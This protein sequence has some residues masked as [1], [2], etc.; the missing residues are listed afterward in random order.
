MDA[1]AP[2]LPSRPSA[3]SRPDR[4]RAIAIGLAAAFLLAAGFA[5]LGLALV[6]AA[7]AV[8]SADASV[9]AALRAV[10][11]SLVDASA[12]ATWL[13]DPRPAL[14]GSVAIAAWLAWR[15]H[16][17]FLV[18]WALAIAGNGAATWALKRTFA[19]M[20][21]LDD[22]GVATSGTPSFPSAH[23]SGLMV[24]CGMLAW[25]AVR[26]LPAR[27]AAA[28]VV[29]CALLVLAVGTSRIL[30]GHHHPSDVLA[31]FLSGG[32]WLALCIVALEW[33]G[34]RLRAARERAAARKRARL[35]AA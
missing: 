2:P 15:R 12:L 35:A 1:T 24:A 32:A 19:R 20:R 17:L 8:R 22:A 30:L 26:L 18:A 10:T 16:G 3:P 6:H 13:G 14:V 27:A 29:A 9:V 31:G 11:R 28:A 21:P 34:P 23:S 5:A 25:F 33:A 7:D 4:R